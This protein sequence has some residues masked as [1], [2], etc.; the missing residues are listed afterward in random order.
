M[1]EISMTKA[2]LPPSLINLQHPSRFFARP[3]YLIPSMSRLVSKSSAQ[4]CLRH[5][6]IKAA[7]LLANG[8]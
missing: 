5:S 4:S 6:S 1:D 7:S 3:F 2:V 8:V